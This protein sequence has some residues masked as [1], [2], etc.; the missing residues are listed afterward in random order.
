MPTIKKVQIYAGGVLV[1]EEDVNVDRFVGDLFKQVFED[2][3]Y[4]Y[5]KSEKALEYNSVAEHRLYENQRLSSVLVKLDLLEQDV[6]EIHAEPA[7]LRMRELRIYGGADDKHTDDE[8]WTRK[9][10]EVV[11]Y[12]LGNVIGPV[13]AMYNF[14]YIKTPVGHDVSIIRLNRE[15]P[16]KD[17]IAELKLLE[18]VIV[19]HAYNISGP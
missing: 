9:T 14:V 19:I 12:K 3:Q 11:H 7:A 2:Y 5:I 8:Y 18:G 6:I 1:K 4:V 10:F 13:F 16:L 17:V 15:M